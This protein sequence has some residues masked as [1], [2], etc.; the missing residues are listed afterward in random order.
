VHLSEH[1][2]RFVRLAGGAPSL[3]LLRGVPQSLRVELRGALFR[4]ADSGVAVEVPPVVV[5]LEGQILQVGVR[6]LP[7]PVLVPGYLLVVFETEQPAPGEVVQLQLKAEPEFA[8]QQVE[9][10]L[11]GMRGH[12]RVTVE[13]YEANTEELKASNEELQAMNEELRSASEE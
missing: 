6:G 8:V 12:L 4:A 1:A 13:Q 2:G 10:E 7:A 11:E 9:R 5:D 3:N